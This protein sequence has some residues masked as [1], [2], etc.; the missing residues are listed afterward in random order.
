MKVRKKIA[1]ILMTGMI[2][3]TGAIG[4]SNALWANYKPYGGFDGSWKRFYGVDRIKTAEYTA[5]SLNPH[6]NASDVYPLQ[7]GQGVPTVLVNSNSFQDGLS[8]Y[9]LCKAFNA[10]LL[11]IKPNYANIGLMRDYYKSKEV[12]LIGGENEIHKS[13]ENYIKRFMPKAR[14]IRIGNK[15]PYERNM[16][17]LKMTGFTN[18]AVADGR[19]FPDALS[20]SGLCN[21]ENLGLRLVDGSKPYS[22]DG[23]NTVYT[24][25]GSDSVVQEGGTRLSGVDRYETAKEVARVSKNYLNI[26]FVDG[27]RFPDSISA[28]NLVKPRTAIV[29]PISDNRDNSDM[30]EFLTLLPKKEDTNSWDIEKCGYALVIGGEPSVADATMQKILYPSRGL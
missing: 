22:S 28:I 13:T 10:R 11:L 6:K 21:L 24:I 9:N 4:S 17:T 12:Y 2:L 19:N 7:E 15:S 29:M 23:F 1:T 30:K 18:V 27:R 20:A 26:L 5:N 3:F 14:V 25:G 8:A 16:E